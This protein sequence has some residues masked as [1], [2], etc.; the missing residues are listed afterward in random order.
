MQGTTLIQL[1]ACLQQ[2][3]CPLDVSVEPHCYTKRRKHMTPST[4]VK[5]DSFGKEF[6]QRL[7]MMTESTDERSAAG[8]QIIIHIP[9]VVQGYL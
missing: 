3:L 2:A 8:P 6:Q 5:I 1:Y 4:V 9:A 7:V